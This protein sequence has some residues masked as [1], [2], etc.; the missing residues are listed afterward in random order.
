[1]FQLSDWGYI[2]EV[3]LSRNVGDDVERF[4]VANGKKNTLGHCVAVARVGAELADRFGVEVELA[5]TAALLHD[6][7]AVLKHQDML[8]YAT[9]N[10]W[11]IDDAELK[12]PFLLHQRVSRVMAEDLF[13]VRD[14]GVLCAIEHHSTLRDGPSA[15]DM[16]LFLADKL[17]W[18]Q[19]GVPPFYGEVSE[20]LDCS[21][22]HAARVYVNYVIEHG[23][24]LY[25]HRWFLD[26]KRWLDEVDQ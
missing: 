10:G 12:Y 16:I 9:R 5:E 6:V 19:E 8:G 11:A 26:A 22:V 14:E 20:A 17:S 25:P 24:I 23:M 2:V 21:L 4:L 1:M 7:S 13:G 3:P 18:D 15:L